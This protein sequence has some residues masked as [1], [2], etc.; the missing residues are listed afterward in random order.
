MTLE[1]FI[2]LWVRCARGAADSVAAERLFDE[3]HAL[4]SGAGRYYHTPAHVTHCLS[5]L[6]MCSDRMQE[7]DEVELAL[8]YHDAVYDPHAADN[9]HQ[10]AQLFLRHA[11]EVLTAE[12]AQRIHDLVLITTHRVE[13]VLLDQKLMVDIDLS[14]FGL[15]WEQFSSESR[16]VRAEFEDLCDAEFYTTQIRFLRTLTSRER[17]FASDFFFERYETQARKNVA[18]TLARLESRGFV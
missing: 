18:R 15:P 5:R 13:P 12:R 7:P 14:G 6:D 16:A 2:A 1:R 8:W 10:S 4:Y 17:F 3:L 11:A 9:E